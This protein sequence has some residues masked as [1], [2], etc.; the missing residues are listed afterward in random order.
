MTLTDESTL[1]SNRKHVSL[2][3]VRNSIA[4]LHHVLLDY[5]VGTE[6]GITVQAMAGSFFQLTCRLCLSCM[7]VALV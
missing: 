6:I 2:S 1:A 7:C 3:F 5:N 4:L